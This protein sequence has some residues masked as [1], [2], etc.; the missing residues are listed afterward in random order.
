MR[1]R[2]IV[3]AMGLLCA[4]YFVEAQQVKTK[5]K[6]VVAPSENTLLTVASQPESALVIEDAKLLLNIDRS[7]DFKFSYKLHNRGSKPIRAFTI[8][9]WTSESSGGTLGHPMEHGPIAPGEKAEFS[10]EKQ[11]TF[12]LPLT[13]ELRE[14]LKVGLPMKLVVIL[15]VENVEFADGSQFSDEKTL[16]ALRD[17]FEGKCN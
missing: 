7:W 11:Q 2:Q 15:M 12:V 10:L 3:A 13:D 9:F 14:K 1:T 16:R 5:S 17:Y 8:H 4:S 6:Y